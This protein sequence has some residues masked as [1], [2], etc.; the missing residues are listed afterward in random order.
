MAFISIEHLI[1]GSNPFVFNGIFLA[2][3]YLAWTINFKSKFA[4]SIGAKVIPKSISE[5]AGIVPL[6]K[7]SLKALFI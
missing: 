4:V 1:T 3:F 7:S 6:L 5:F 2:T